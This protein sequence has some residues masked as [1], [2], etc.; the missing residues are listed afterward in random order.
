MP[1]AA[2]RKAQDIK[3]SRYAAAHDTDVFLLPLMG[4]G[5]PEEMTEGLKIQYPI[6]EGDLEL[7]STP[8]DFI[9][10]NYYFENAVVWDEDNILK[11]KE[12]PSCGPHTCMGWPIV[13]SG[14]KRILEYF[15]S[16]SSGMPL[17]ITENGIACDDVVVDGRVRDYE[18]CDY[19]RKHFQVCADAI[20]AGIPLKGYFVW[21]FIDNFEWAFGYSRRF[22]IVHCDFTSQ[23]RTVKDSA[24]M[25]RDYI[26]GYD[27]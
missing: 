17:Y 24:Y 7:I 26:A 6:E 21:S 20:D 8:F 10:I 19:L 11:N 9:G 15:T 27:I 22:G 25:I 23:K 5:Y 12:V 14:L 1:R 4:K 16:V 3:A 18:R 2:S 13:P